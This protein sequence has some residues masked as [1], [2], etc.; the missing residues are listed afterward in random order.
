[1][2]AEGV[3]R[4]DIVVVVQPRLTFMPSI[5]QAQEP[6]CVKALC[7]DLAIKGLRER[8]VR[9]HIS[10]SRDKLEWVSVR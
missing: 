5:S 6:V 1:M 4:A 7:P 10:L 2:V 8:V 9:R 3:M